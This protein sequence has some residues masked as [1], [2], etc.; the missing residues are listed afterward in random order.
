VKFLEEHG[1]FAGPFASIAG[2]A[3]CEP[4]SA[5]EEEEVTRIGEGCTAWEVHPG[6]NG[7]TDIL[8]NATVKTT[9]AFGACFAN[10]RPLFNTGNQ[11]TE[12]EKLTA[13]T[14]M[15]NVTETEVGANKKINGPDIHPTPLGYTEIGK[16]MTKRTNSTCKKEGVPGF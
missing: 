6:F 11:T 16:L 7:L 9:K 14:N 2:A 8:N 4:H 15:K 1:G 5:T 13:Y 12:P 3:R 10:P